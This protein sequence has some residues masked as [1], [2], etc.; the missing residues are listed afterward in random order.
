MIQ[1]IFSSKSMVSGGFPGKA[2]LV[3][4]PPVMQET[5]VRSLG[6]DD[7]LERGR[8]THPSVLDWRIPWTIPWGHNELDTTEQLSFHFTLMVSKL[9]TIM[10]PSPIHHHTKLHMLKILYLTK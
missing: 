10:N 2:Q 5:P 4:S 3:K 1:W 9:L 6:W 7:P 8:A